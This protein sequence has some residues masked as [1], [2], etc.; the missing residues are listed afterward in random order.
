MDT[1][2]L[3]ALIPEYSLLPTQRYP[4]FSLAVLTEWARFFLE[5]S[6]YN[7]LKRPALR[8]VLRAFAQLVPQLRSLLDS[9]V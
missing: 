1:I 4:H 2:L 9:I 3:A 8:W 5:S 7:K 6:P